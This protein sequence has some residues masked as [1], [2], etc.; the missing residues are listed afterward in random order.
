VRA[1]VAL[2]AAFGILGAAAC[3]SDGGAPAGPAGP[4]GPAAKFSEIYPLIYPLT[5]NARCDFCHSLPANNISNGGLHMGS[6]PAAAVAGLVGK[7]STNSM[8]THQTLVVPGK[9]DE[10]LFLQK[11]SPNPPC[12][13]RMPVGG[14][15]LPDDQLA[16]IRSWIAAGALDD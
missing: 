15:V 16:M 5:T 7:Q 9:P 2:A 12:G 8:C 11:L 4:A 10:S 1:I 13:S 14:K 3:G 6:D